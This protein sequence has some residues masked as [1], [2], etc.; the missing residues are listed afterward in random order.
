MPVTNQA[1]WAWALFAMSKL[2][3]LRLFDFYDFFDSPFDTSK[4]PPIFVKI[5]FLIDALQGWAPP[6]WDQLAFTDLK[7]V[8]PTLG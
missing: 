2:E 8:C 5:S 6:I 1:L 4:T 3:K 7:Q